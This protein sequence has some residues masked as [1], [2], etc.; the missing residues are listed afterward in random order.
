MYNLEWL[1]ENANRRYPFKEETT[2]V[3]RSE[4]YQLPNTFLVDG[5]FMLSRNFELDFHVGRVSYSPDALTI[6]VNAV[7]NE[8]TLV[9]T[10]QAPDPQLKNSTIT[11]F[12]EGQ[13]VGSFGRFTIGSLE[14]LTEGEFDFFRTETAIEPCRIVKLNQGISA[15]NGI[16]SGNVILKSGAN[17]VITVVG[18]KI[19]IESFDGRCACENCPCIKTINGIPPKGND[20][21]IEGIGCVSIGAAQNGIEIANDCEEACCGCQEVNDFLTRLR[22]LEERIIILEANLP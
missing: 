17:T 6:T 14:D 16:T 15:I 20:F 22:D 7:D 11:L 10:I 19:Q 5:L 13:Y 4:R 21:R 3:D 8:T 12:G 2:L 9:G 18:K 1:N